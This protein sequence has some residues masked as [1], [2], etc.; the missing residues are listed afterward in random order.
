MQ[1]FGNY[2]PT[3]C[4]VR[5]GCENINILIQTLFYKNAAYN[6]QQIL[7]FVFLF[8]TALSQKWGL[9]E[10]LPEFSEDTSSVQRRNRPNSYDDDIVT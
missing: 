7:T 10:E 3:K 9:L 6:I 4:K 1:I 2:I 5:R 8:L